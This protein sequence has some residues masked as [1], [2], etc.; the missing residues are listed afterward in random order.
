MVILYYLYLVAP[1]SLEFLFLKRG[2][3]DTKASASKVTK[4][5]KGLDEH[6][7]PA[8][9]QYAPWV[10]PY[11][12]RQGEPHAH[13]PLGPLHLRGLPPW[14][15]SL[16]R[17]TFQLHNKYCP[18]SGTLTLRCLKPPSQKLLLPVALTFILDLWRLPIF[19]CSVSTVVPS[20]EEAPKL[21]ESKGGGSC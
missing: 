3:T 2:D 16:P 18:G 19:S 1:N 4:A 12:P 21:A 6:T 17:A 8:H 15:H 7:R 13:D 9:L 11:N 5:R 14:P 10:A 20:L